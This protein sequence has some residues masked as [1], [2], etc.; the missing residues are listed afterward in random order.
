MRAKKSGKVFNICCSS[1]YDE[2]QCL[3]GSGYYVLVCI[4]YVTRKV[5]VVGI[6]QQPNGAWMEHMARNLTDPLSGF[7]EGKNT[8]SMTGIHSLQRSSG[9]LYKV[10]L[11]TIVVDYNIWMENFSHECA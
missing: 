11:S 6:S 7:L 2:N 10:K 8:S 3:G 1:S 5:K 9:G 4:D